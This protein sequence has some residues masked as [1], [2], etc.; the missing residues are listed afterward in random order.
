MQKINLKKTTKEQMLN[1][2]ETA[3]QAD[4]GANEE[5]AALS[6]R[7]EE[8]NDLLSECA[9]EKAALKAECYDLRGKLA[10]AEKALE[11]AES[12][13]ASVQGK[14]ACANDE[15]VRLKENLGWSESR[16]NWAASHPWSNLW[17]WIKRKLFW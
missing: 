13:V 9:N 8:Q 3:W 1:M 2:L 10:D 6:K 12:V 15:I 17:A 11:R 7:I 14:L 16:A 5:I 4:A